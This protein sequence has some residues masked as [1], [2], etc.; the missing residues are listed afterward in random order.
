MKFSLK[1]FLKKY[2]RHMQVAG[3]LVASLSAGFYSAVQDSNQIASVELEQKMAVIAMCDSSDN[4]RL[5]VCEKHFESVGN[6]VATVEWT[7]DD[8]LGHDAR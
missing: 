3:V 7:W 5:E 4:Y 2:D 6:T 8:G 1:A